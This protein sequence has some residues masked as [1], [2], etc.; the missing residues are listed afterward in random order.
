MNFG[1]LHIILQLIVFEQK[2]LYCT[3]TATSA[4]LI[5]MLNLTT[6]KITNN[7]NNTYK[8]YCLQ[9]LHVKTKISDTNRATINL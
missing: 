8:F 2:L 5:N 6:R 3:F 1:M 4:T 7:N 9:C